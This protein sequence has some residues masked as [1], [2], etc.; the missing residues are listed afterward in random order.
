VTI[1]IADAQLFFLVLV[2]VLAVLMVTPILSTR[3]YPAQAKIG[4]ALFLTWMLFSVQPKIDEPWEML[5]YGIAISH[6]LFTGLLAGFASL[7]TFVSL[8]MAAT[9]IGLQSGT[10]MANMLNPSLS[11]LVQVQGSA[12]EQLYTMVVVL[13]FLIVGGHHLVIAGIQRTFTLVPAGQFILSPFAF[14]R[15]MLLMGMMFNT[16]LYISMPVLGTQLLVSLAL[17]II[18]RVVPQVPVIFLGAP[19]K[20]GLGILT[21]ML[22]LPWMAGF[23]IDKVSRVADDVLIFVAP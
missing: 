19:L 12:L 15:L 20:M 1:S 22:A 9:Y 11:D 2:R 23:I 16:A 6:E 18:S 21:L 7:V 8:Q 5:T 17:A 10:R 4:M 14:D 3:R 13:L